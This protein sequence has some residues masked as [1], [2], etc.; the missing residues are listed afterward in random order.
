MNTKGKDLEESVWYGVSC[1][2]A[3][4]MNAGTELCKLKDVETLYEVITTEKINF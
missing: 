1:G 3:A 4:T 2:T